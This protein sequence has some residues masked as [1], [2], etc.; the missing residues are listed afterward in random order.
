MIRIILRNLTRRRGRTILTVLGIAVGVAAIVALGAM[1]RAM[2]AGYSAMLGGSKADLVLSQPNSF[3]IAYSSVDDNLAPSLLAM[4]EVADVSGMLQGYVQAE[5]LP[6]FF[7]F[8]YPPESFIL[9][10]LQLTQGVT[11]DDRS[12]GLERGTPLLLGAVAAESLDRAVGDTL[13]LADGIYRIVGIFESGDALQDSGAVLRIEDAQNLLGKPRQVSLYYLQLEDP[14]DRPRVEARMA[15]LFPDLEVSGTDDFADKQLLDDAL[16]AYAYGLAGLAIIIGGVGMMN[17]QLMSINERTREIG[18]LRAVGWRKARV[19]LMILAESLSLGLL[20]GLLG[21]LL[22]WLSLRA[23]RGA[24]VM[25]GISQAGVSPDLV[26]QGL[27]LVC[28][29]GVVAGLYP[30]YRASRLPPVEALRYEGGSG[31][32]IRRLPFGG[33]ELQS[34]WQRSSRTLLT[35]AAIGLTVGTIMAMEAIIRGVSAEMTEI[36]VGADAQVVLRQ[37]DISD[38]S[39]SAIDERIGELIAGLPEVENVSG[40]VMAAAMLPDNA[41]FF[42]MQGYAPHEHAIRRFEIVEGGPLTGNHQVLLGR[43]MADA[44]RK[45]IGETIDVSGHRYRVV[46]IFE[47]GVGWEELGGVVSLREAQAFAGRPRKVT[48]YLVKMKDPERA[49]ALVDRINREFPEVHAALAGEFAETMPDMQNAERFMTALSLMTILVGGV[50]VLNTMLMAVHERTREIGVLRAVGWG[51]R[52][53]LAMVMKE[54]VLLALLGGVTG[55]LFALWLVWALNRIPT[56][57]GLLAPLWEW[58]VFVRAVLVALM[59]GVIGGLYPAY[60]ATRMQ[61]VEALRYE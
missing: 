22:G 1:A 23:V 45:T 31:G 25:F 41:G 20:G 58:D 8:G 34:L 53:V 59:L 44:M 4:P 35:F 16:Q 36:G 60:R 3:D 10:R 50:G 37:A 39:L 13:R 46:G 14:A 12:T 19:L 27:G 61:P 5:S 2:N 51:R 17:A 30:A 47:S 21:L 38:T 29:L 52:R 48:L 54:S 43:M 55:I 28:T 42:V 57:E 32:K 26:L 49:A 15:R 6:F 40:M 33:M 24:G 56:M 18:V 11:L 7:V 9:K